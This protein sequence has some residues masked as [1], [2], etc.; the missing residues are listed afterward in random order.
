MLELLKENLKNSYAPYSNFH[1]SAVLVTDS[2][3]KYTGV[4]I[5]NASYGATVCAERVA[6]LKAISE[7]ENPSSFKEIHIISDG[8]KKAMPCF[9]CRQVFAEF[10]RDDIEIYV[11][12]NAL[13]VSKYS[14]L[15]VCPNPFSK[16]DLQ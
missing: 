1:V 16:E 6:I 7:G 11:Y 15:D 13:N 3:K 9:I 5:E 10:F 2:G 8:G 4:N 14:L 12:D